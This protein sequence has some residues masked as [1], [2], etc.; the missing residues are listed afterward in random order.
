M[1]FVPLCVLSCAVC[2]TVND[3]IDAREKESVCQ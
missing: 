1:A 2:A 3:L